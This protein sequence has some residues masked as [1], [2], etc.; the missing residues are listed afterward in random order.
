MSFV[1]EA[2]GREVSSLRENKV[3]LLL[4]SCTKT[5]FERTA[6]IDPAAA[7]PAPLRAA[8]AFEGFTVEDFKPLELDLVEGLFEA[9]ATERLPCGVPEGATTFLVFFALVFFLVFALLVVAT[10]FLTVVSAASVAVCAR[11]GAPA[12][13]KL[14][15][16]RHP[17]QDFLQGKLNLKHILNALQSIKTMQI[18]YLALISN[19]VFYGNLC[20]MSGI[21]G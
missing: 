2:M 6:L 11:S 19:L 21:T 16:T 14:R 13:V 10:G 3:V 9:S 15:L 1:I 20:E 17:S 5:T 7:T 18:I 12:K 8:G 4:R